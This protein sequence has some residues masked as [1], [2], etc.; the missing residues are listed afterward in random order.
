MGMNQLKARQACFETARFVATTLALCSN[1]DELRDTLSELRLERYELSANTRGLAMLRAEWR[2]T[3]SDKGQS[4]YIS[5]FYGVAMA[6]THTQQPVS[7]TVMLDEG[8]VR[9][10]NQLE[11]LATGREE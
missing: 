6:T 5:P 9:L 4:V 3:I 2:G 7:S 1:K 8:A 11:D 10:L